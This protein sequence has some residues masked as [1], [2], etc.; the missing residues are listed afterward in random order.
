MKQKIEKANST[1][2]TG[3]VT[4]NSFSKINPMTE[5]EQSL[6]KKALNRLYAKPNELYPIMSQVE[7]LRPSDSEIAVA[8]GMLEALLE[9]EP[10]D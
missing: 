6:I 5:A 4:I 1:P 7:Y 9:S 2:Q 8:I 3:L 10:K